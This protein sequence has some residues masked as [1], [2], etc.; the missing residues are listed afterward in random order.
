M[1]SPRRRRTRR[2]VEIAA[3]VHDEPA[4]GYAPSVPLNEASVVIVL[5]PGPLE[6]RAVRRCAA[7][8]RRAVEI[9][10]AVHDQPA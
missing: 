8:F 1:P 10:A 7:V 5:L 4:N 3:G 6:N 2:A 9:A